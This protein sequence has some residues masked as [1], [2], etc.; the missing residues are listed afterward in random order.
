MRTVCIL[1]A[2]CR[3]WG[4]GTCRLPWGRVLSG[5]MEAGERRVAQPE[6]DPRTDYV[7]PPRR[8]AWFSRSTAPRLPRWSSGGLKWPSTNGS[9]PVSPTP[10]EDQWK[11]PSGCR[12]NAL[13]AE[14]EN[15]PEP[16]PQLDPD[17]R[18]ARRI[19]GFMRRDGRWIT[20]NELYQRRGYVRLRRQW[21]TVQEVQLIEED[22]PV[23]RSITTGFGRSRRTATNW[24][25]ATEP[26]RH[27]GAF[28][29]H[30]SGGS[31]G[32]RKGT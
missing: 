18:R 24:P 19:L 27:A 2:F 32:V 7:R 13:V 10:V 30:R 20:R 17:P 28:V 8:K 12:E 3:S 22:A 9:G 1:I 16:N 5:R 25:P 31:R 29:H 15:P 26:L 23:A 14:R 21:R 4:P 6:S 11:S